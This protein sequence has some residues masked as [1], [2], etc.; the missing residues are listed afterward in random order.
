MA[1]AFHIA[2]WQAM[3]LCSSELGMLTRVL[4]W[5]RQTMNVKY[6]DKFHMHTLEGHEVHASEAFAERQCIKF[7]V[8]IRNHVIRTKMAKYKHCT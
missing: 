5:K 2:A 4:S 3:I 6:I 7:N 1:G 8:S